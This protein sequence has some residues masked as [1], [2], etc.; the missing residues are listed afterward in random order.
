MGWLRSGLFRIG[1]KQIGDSISYTLKEFTALTGQDEIRSLYKDS[2]KNI[3]VG[4]R[5]GGAFCLTPNGSEN[6]DVQRFNRQSGI[7][8]DW[9]KS[10]AETKSGIFG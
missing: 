4:T 8:S 5:Y 2:K 3:W 9:V 10:F 7:M 6:F 1:I